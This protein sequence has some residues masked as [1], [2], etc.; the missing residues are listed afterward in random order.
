R[1]PEVLFEEMGYDHRHRYLVDLFDAFED[2]RKQERRITYADM[3]YEPVQAISQHPELQQ[4]VADK[5]DV[6][7]VDEYQDTNE[8]QHQLLGY[9][10]GRRAKVTVVGDP[11]QT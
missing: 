2:W 3:L 9:V 6:I 8:V 7:L 11:D 4:L 1:D 5:M 10:A